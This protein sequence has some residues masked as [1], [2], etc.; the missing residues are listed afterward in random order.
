MQWIIPPETKVL[1]LETKIGK[2]TNHHDVL[3]E[4][5]YEQDI[6]EY[7]AAYE[8]D[9]DADEGDQVI[10]SGRNSLKLASPGGEIVDIKVEV[11]DKLHSDK[12]LIEL[13]KQL[14]DRTKSIK[15]RLEKGKIG[16]KEQIR[17]AD[18]LEMKFF[19]VG[20]H[21]YKGQEFKGVRVSYLIKTGKPLR[22][23]D[24][25]ANR[26]GAK[27]IISKIYDEK[28]HAESSGGIDIFISPLS[29]FGR[30]NLALVKE[31]YL[32]KLTYNLNKKIIKMANNEKVK[33]DTIIKLINDY[34][35]CIC[36]K[37]TQDS[38]NKKINN[39]STPS[40]FRKVVSK[41]EFVIFTIIEPFHNVSF[42]QIKSAS[43]LLNVKLDEYVTIKGPDGKI[44][45]T[46]RPVPVGY[47][48]L[49]FLEHFSSQYASVGGAAKYSGLSKQP[50]NSS[51]IYL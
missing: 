44:R 15:T 42:E 28:P 21:K 9:I 47:T 34:N 37:K 43:K 13:H 30:K 5:T 51:G 39:Y 23:G 20:G 11:N 24:K 27:G 46:D 4:F 19:K 3:C 12:R 10:S 16:S 18:N 22:E 36:S 48:Y 33:T 14:V 40:A 26:Y 45:K 38:V 29:V 35:K 32:G 50:V 8:L 6:D 7:L 1:N 41:G 49:Q 25:L 2:E 31:L 17:A